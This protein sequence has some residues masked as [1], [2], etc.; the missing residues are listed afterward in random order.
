MSSPK[1]INNKKIIEMYVKDANTWRC[2]QQNRSQ[3]IS[4][5]RGI[6]HGSNMG[7]GCQMLGQSCQVQCSFS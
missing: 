3:S 7:A 1:T 5:E 6:T 2:Y 4:M